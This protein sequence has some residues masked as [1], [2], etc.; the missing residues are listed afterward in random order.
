MCIVALFLGMLF[1]KMLMD[2]CGCKDIV[3]GIA[4]PKLVNWI[5]DNVKD[6]EGATTRSFGF[7]IDYDIEKNLREYCK[8]PPDQRVEWKAE[9][10]NNQEIG[11]KILIGGDGDENSGLTYKQ[12]SDLYGPVA[13]RD[14]ILGKKE[15]GGKSRTV[16]D[17]LSAWSGH[18]GGADINKLKDLNICSNCVDDRVRESTAYNPPRGDSCDSALDGEC[19]VPSY[20]NLGTDDSDCMTNNTEPGQRRPI[21]GKTYSYDKC[22]EQDFRPLC[23][24]VQNAIWKDCHQ[25]PEGNRCKCDDFN[26]F[27]DGCILDH[28][29][30]SDTTAAT[31]D[32][33]EGAGSKVNGMSTKGVCTQ[34]HG[35]HSPMSLRHTEA[36]CV[37][38]LCGPCKDAC[39][40][41]HP[42]VNRRRTAEYYDCTQVCRDSGGCSGDGGNPGTWTY[43][44]WTSPPAT[45]TDALSGTG[46]YFNTTTWY[47]GSTRVNCDNTPRDPGALAVLDTD[48]SGALSVEEIQSG[49]L[50]RV[51]TNAPTVAGAATGKASPTKPPTT[52]PP[53]SGH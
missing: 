41:A 22:P 14:T 21:T 18:E 53:M 11:N 29:T 49:I 44:T 34:K 37:E 3:E 10:T 50:D 5:R 26:T 13:W 24:V 43:A 19:D 6:E 7:P 48:G 45:A 36:K 35:H 8:G 31:K 15:K 47:D 2:V 39:E 52:Q 51:Q 20:C 42:A 33:C 16:N 4:N 17:I 38:D 32:T 25:R 9:P 28:G 23:G 46:T 40:V 1:T 12:M 27:L 30:C